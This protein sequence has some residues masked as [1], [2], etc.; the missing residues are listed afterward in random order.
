[1]AAA[2]IVIV[3]L[4][5]WGLFALGWIAAARLGLVD[6]SIPAVPFLLMAAWFVGLAVIAF[7]R[8]G[9]RFGFPLRAVMEAADRVADGN[10]TVRVG[11][12]GPP[13]MRALAQAFN[14]MT[15]RLERN[16]EQRRNLMADV[17]HELR[18]PLTVIQGRVEG[19]LD[20]VYPRDDAGLELVLEETRVLSRLIDDLRTLALS[21]AGVLKL[22]REAT[23]VAALARDVAEAFAGDAGG[24]GVSIE[25]RD[26]ANTTI[27]ID[28]VRIREVLTNLVSNALRH[29]GAGGAVTISVKGTDTHGIAVA[30]T[31]TGAGMTSEEAQQVFGRFYKGTESRG[32]GL[33]LAIAHGLVVAHGGS[34]GVSSEPG[35]GTTIAFTLP[36]DGEN[37]GDTLARP[38]IRN[39]RVE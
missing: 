38:S 20:G 13:P 25:V 7:L 14:T 12:H 39:A 8:V 31:D 23:D 15:E 26:E 35:R 24:R 2:A 36:P 28:P 32:S 22:E 10:Y 33:G 4:G 9:R 17:A 6:P 16:D 30:V 11:V 37:H 21:E 1:M 5:V 27:E 29:T 34:I 3:A 19:L 18:T